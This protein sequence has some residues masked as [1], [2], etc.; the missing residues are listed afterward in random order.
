MKKP[1]SHPIVHWRIEHA[2]AKI[3]I[4][5]QSIQ[6]A[7]KYLKINRLASFFSRQKLP[8]YLMLG[9][10]NS[11]KT[12]LLKTKELRL[13]SIDNQ[14]IQ[15]NTNPTA[16]CDWWFGQEAVFI[17]MS[18]SLVLPDDPK[19][20]SHLIWNTFISLLHRYRRTRP[21]DGIILCIDLHE[22]QAKQRGQRQL[23]IDILR[24][25]IQTFTKFQSNLPIYLIFTKCDRIPGF[26]DSF[27]AL[28]PEDC[29]QPFGISLPFGIVQQIF[30]HQL[31]EKFNAF[32][33][34]LNQQLLGR[35]HREHNIEKR[36]QIKNFPLQ[37]E[38]LKRDIINLAAQLH[39]TKTSFGGI[40]FTSS[41]Q[42]GNTT[43]AL[44]IV[45]SNF[46][47]PIFL[48]P[49]NN[50][51]MPQT[52]AFFIQQVLRK[53]AHH[54]IPRSPKFS[55]LLLIKKKHFYATI[56]GL[57]LA[58]ILSLVSSYLYNKI[59]IDHA[60]QILNHFS[61]RPE[62]AR[63][64]VAKGQ[65]EENGLSNSDDFLLRLNGLY[66][67]TQET[68]SYSNVLVSSLFN[69]V[70]SLH[71]NLA[72]NYEYSLKT[73]L[74]SFIT[75]TL[76]TQI[77]QGTNSKP[78][79]VFSALKVYLMLNDPSHLDKNFIMEW[80]KKYWQ[81]TDP[82]HEKQWLNHL[83]HW[84]ALSNK[85]FNF[86][87]VI[88]QQARQK[89]NSLPL[90]ELTYLNLQEKY[91][92]ISLDEK[93]NNKNIASFSLPLLSLFSAAN[94]ANIYNQEIPEL[95]QRL[96]TGDDWVLNLKLPANLTEPLTSQI[97]NSVRRLYL[98]RY[99]AFWQY[100]LLNIRINHFN[101]L[102]EA[103]HF[104]NNFLATDAS[105]LN[106]I[107]Q[108]E[109]NLQP[110][111]Q[112]AEANQA[113]DAMQQIRHSL[114]AINNNHSL[115]QT[116][117]DLN[118]YLAPITDATDP[119]LATLNATQL[120]MKKNGEGDPI[121]QLLYQAKSSPE[122]VKSW[123]NAVAHN[124]W[125]SMLQTSRNHL[126]LLWIAEVWP[127]YHGQIQNRYPIFRDATNEIT[128]AEF[129]QFFAP[130]GILDNFIAHNVLGFVDHSQLY[131]QWKYLDG[132]RLD[133][134]QAALEMFNRASL[135]RKM[136]F[137]DNQKTPQVKFTITPTSMQYMSG[138][139]LLNLEGQQINYLRD[140]REAKT[141]VWPGNKAGIA[142]LEFNTPSGVM[143]WKEAGDWA[144]Y[145]LLARAQWSP[146]ANTRLYTL[147]FMVNGIS[148]PYELLADK[149]INPFIP[150]IVTE[151]RCPE[152]L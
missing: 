150:N 70:V 66:N 74:S 80:F 73:K 127:T 61:I 77:Q 56:G 79:Q 55:A 9:A 104:A 108:I 60:Q 52:K 115:H 59:K 137:V 148:I 134:P 25:R 35:L 101:D 16:Y 140:F 75:S 133:I 45:S 62:E 20:D 145:K 28:S 120:R 142:T 32:L 78:Q 117:R 100:Q 130:H 50:Y 37:L 63:S 122:P 146:S 30:P 129:T 17:D 29:Q 15:F 41:V 46:G 57:F 47:L 152:K 92:T 89:L 135:I 42:D 95:A 143:T 85:N 4:L 97:I 91:E 93:P 86:N 76:E 67:A 13:S 49:E 113:I 8:W 109:S 88:A 3:Q 106:L 144:L 1:V 38:A 40:Y 26:T 110:L 151:F 65:I 6:D 23:Q 69:Q 103:R 22:F 121:S 139:Y 51:F 105:I 118:K 94:F 131:W 12:S 90:P 112:F 18:G 114:A 27:N 31:E 87:A 24:H 141:I 39:S 33:Q 71:T 123:L 81:Q 11:G 138:N 34:R 107:S 72:A 54:K 99:A 111:T 124:T 132:E 48:K 98:Q 53:I 116:L 2:Q 126:N 136:Y 82:A 36:A 64:A 125:H 119:A 5:Q 43:D 83:N 147:N 44:A 19:N 128:L 21:V 68:N 84:L 7:L 58:A 14:P 10:E 96:A 102:S 149:P